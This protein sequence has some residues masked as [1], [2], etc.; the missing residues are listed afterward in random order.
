MDFKVEWYDKLDS[1]N[2]CMHDRFHSDLKLPNGLI[3]AAREQTAG[4]GRQD[5]NWISR[6]DTNLCFSAFIETNAPLIE[7][8]SLTMAVALGIVE[9]L[10]PAGIRAA[11]KWPN[12]VL[13]GDKKICGILS[14]RVEHPT[15]RRT[16]IIAGIGLNVN[17][18]TEEAEAIDRP[19]TS[20]LIEKG[21]AYDLNHSLEALFEP[22][23]Y[24]IKEWEKGGFSKLQK[25]WT[26]KAGPIGKCLAVHDGDIRK[27]GVLAG[28]G[29]Y[30]ELLLETGNGIETIWSGDVSE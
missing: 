29:E 14:E 9:M 8:P 7:V 27:R 13:V 22:L 6:S 10:V 25:I 16:G 1:T 2:T 26:E 19:A 11:P 21:R 12:D 4:R 17:M 20:M 28:F 3:I 30:G 15:T 5:R 24:W 18:T 23:D